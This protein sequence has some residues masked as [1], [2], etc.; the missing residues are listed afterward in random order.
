MDT[1]KCLDQSVPA[2]GT[3]TD[4]YAVPASTS[5]VIS[6]IKVCNQGSVATTF[7]ISIAI[8]GAAD[9]AAQYI[10]YDLPIYPKDTY[11]ATEGWTL[12]T[13]D[14]IRASSANGLCSFNIFGLEIT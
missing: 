1:F 4:L 9:T 11:S 13:T 14:V 12:A 3:L 6:T 7:R 10:Y 5:S 8:A 2:A